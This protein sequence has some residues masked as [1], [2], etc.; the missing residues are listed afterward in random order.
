MGGSDSQE[1]WEGG[2]GFWVDALY[3]SREQADFFFWLTER[4]ETRH[5]LESE[6]F[7]L[8]LLDYCK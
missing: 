3:I 7:R 1:S 4:R 5:V 6:L 8:D 2:V